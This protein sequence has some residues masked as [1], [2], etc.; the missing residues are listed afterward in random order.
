MISFFPHIRCL[1]NVNYPHACCC[2]DDDASTFFTG[3][4]FFAA[5]LR[6]EAL[7]AAK[8]GKVRRINLWNWE[9]SYDQNMRAAQIQPSHKPN[10]ST[11][12]LACQHRW[13]CNE[14]FLHWQ[15]TDKLILRSL[16]M[17]VY[18]SVRFNYSNHFSN[19]QRNGK[20]TR[21]ILLFKLR[22]QWLSCMHAAK[23]YVEQSLGKVGRVVG[24]LVWVKRTPIVLVL[25]ACSRSRRSPFGFHFILRIFAF[26][27][28][29]LVSNHHH[30]EQHQQHERSENEWTKCVLCVEIENCEH[31]VLL[32]LLSHS[33]PYT[34]LK[35]HAHSSDS[36]SAHVLLFIALH[37]SH[38]VSKSQKKHGWKQ[39][40]NKR[41]GYSG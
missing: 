14:F 27:L 5:F 18:T 25:L 17:I 10:R 15:N 23:Q 22:E 4:C 7:R 28:P 35:L 26:F 2:I 12:E 6:C 31:R 21:L 34:W 30:S 32:L 40:I 3:L 19:L 11:I 9:M 16:F 8:Q 20:L 39:Y 29:S 38:R 24:L 36:D 37:I 41:I 33:I 1:F 13:P